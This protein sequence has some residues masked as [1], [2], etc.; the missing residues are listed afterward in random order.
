MSKYEITKEAHTL[1]EILTVIMM[2]A[3]SV[4]IHA[5]RIRNVHG[6]ELFNSVRDNPGLE[7]WEIILTV[8]D[9]QRYS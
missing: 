3:P 4:I 9:K 1:G 7:E 2:L 8:S 6:T 5:M